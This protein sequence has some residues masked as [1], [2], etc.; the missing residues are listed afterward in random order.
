MVNVEIHSFFICPKISVS[1]CHKSVSRKVEFSVQTKRFFGNARWKQT[2]FLRD[3]CLVW[4]DSLGNSFC[5]KPFVD[6]ANLHGTP[7]ETF[8]EVGLQS[9]IS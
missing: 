9:S 5:G 7:V 4:H 8:N 2:K 3:P 1:Q 6:M